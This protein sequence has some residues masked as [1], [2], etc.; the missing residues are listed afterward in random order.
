MRPLHHIVIVGV[1]VNHTTLINVRE[2]KQ[3][4]ENYM[5]SDSAVLPLDNIIADDAAST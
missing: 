2:K 3:L 1:A 5:A 4:S